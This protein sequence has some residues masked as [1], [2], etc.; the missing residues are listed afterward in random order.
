M[1]CLSY[2]HLLEVLPDEHHGHCVQLAVAEQGLL[3]R[4]RALGVAELEHRVGRE[5]GAMNE[6]C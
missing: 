5:G 3:Q 2:S 6:G 1:V 4:I